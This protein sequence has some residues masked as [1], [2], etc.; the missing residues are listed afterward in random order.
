MGTG[1]HLAGLGGIASSLCS[2]V[3]ANYR[4]CLADDWDNRVVIPE[5]VRR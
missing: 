5:P 3:H 4:S 1:G 2:D